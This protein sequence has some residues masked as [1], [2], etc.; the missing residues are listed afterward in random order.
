MGPLLILSGPTASGKT[1]LIARLLADKT[2]PLR[3]SVSVTTRPPRPGEQDGRHYHFWSRERFQQEVSAAAFL[4][5]AEVYGNFYGTL[6]SEVEPFRRQ[7]MA[8][9]LEIDVKGWEQVKRRCP[10]AVAIFL[11]TSSLDVYEKRL[12]QRKTENEAAIQRRLEGVRAELARAPQYDYQVVNDDLEA[13]VERVRNIVREH[14][15]KDAGKDV[16]GE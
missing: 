9:L 11:Q 4:E 2:L 1:T 12:R 10:E 5:W 14:V 16:G 8:V 6:T 7:G 13:A 3:L 15:S